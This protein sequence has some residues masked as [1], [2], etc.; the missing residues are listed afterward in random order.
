MIFG[1]GNDLAAVPRFTRLHA[2]HG[3]RTL[4]K[5]LSPA[6]RDEFRHSSHPGSFLAKHFAAKE[7]LAKALGIGVRH[8]VLL[9]AITV[10]H[11]AL[12][13]P[14]FRYSG[15]L[16]AWMTERRLHAHLSLSDENDLVAAFVV[17]EQE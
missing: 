14:V 3:E 16:A 8:P 5:L 2:R 4:E 12:G 6:E 15:E 13:K 10:G 11:D 9:P 17:V 1:I 7:A